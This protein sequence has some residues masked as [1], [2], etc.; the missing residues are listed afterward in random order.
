MGLVVFS[1]ELTDHTISM[2]GLQHTATK[3]QDEVSI[4]KFITKRHFIYKYQHAWSV[5]SGFVLPGKS[6]TCCPGQTKHDLAGNEKPLTKALKSLVVKELRLINILVLNDG[7]Y[8]IQIIVFGDTGLAYKC[9][10]LAET[11][12][13]LLHMFM[14]PS[15]YQKHIVNNNVHTC[16]LRCIIPHQR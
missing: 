7:I 14:L 11:S 6:C 13:P 9:G 15:I 3:H 5:M 8:F 1:D 2:G 16:S 12:C 4:L 10:N